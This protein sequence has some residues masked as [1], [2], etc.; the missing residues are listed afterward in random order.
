M[1]KKCSLFFLNF[2]LRQSKNVSRNE[3][4]SSQLLHGSLI[5]MLRKRNDDPLRI[6]KQ[7]QRATY[8]LYPPLRMMFD[9]EH[10]ARSVTELTITPNPQ[11]LL[12]H[13]LPLGTILFLA[14]ACLALFLP[15]SFFH[16][17]VTTIHWY[18]SLSDN[19][20]S[21][22]IEVHVFPAK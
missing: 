22:V 18:T 13:Q 17:R 19:N 3:I 15:F 21:G 9:M 5:L 12:W 1:P 20:A 4:E 2:F 14:R 16:T 11:D 8:V 10:T 7:R 6:S